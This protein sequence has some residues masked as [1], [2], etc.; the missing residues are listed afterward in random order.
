MAGPLR[1]VYETVIATTP[2]RLWRAITRLELVQK[3]FYDMRLKT[4]LEPGAPIEY[5]GRDGKAVIT[6]RVVKVVPRKLLVHTFAFEDAKDPESRVTYKIEKAGR[7]VRLTL[8][9][10]RFPRKTRTYRSVRGGWVPILSGLKT[11][12]ETGK[13]LVM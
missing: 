1:H 11:F 13:R 4:T 3:Y 2:E 7:A 12:L 10:D 9:H 8:I 6:G 5:V